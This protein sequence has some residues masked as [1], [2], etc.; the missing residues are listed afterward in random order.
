LGTTAGTWFVRTLGKAGAAGCGDT[1]A[2]GN[3]TGSG[4]CGSCGTKRPGTVSDWMAGTGCASTSATGRML[5]ATA[6][7]SVV[8]LITRNA[9]ALPMST[10]FGGGGAITAVYGAS[11]SRSGTNSS[12]DSD[13]IS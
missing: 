13:G 1:T 6:T 3:A 5:T 8:K 2:T 9:I 10:V 7:A 11:S 4:S 12:S